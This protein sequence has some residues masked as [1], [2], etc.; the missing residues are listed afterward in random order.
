MK[1]DNSILPGVAAPGAKTVRA[2]KGAR[3]N[4]K[5]AHA[6]HGDNVELGITTAQLLTYETQLKEVEGVDAAKV[7]EVRRAIAEGR[8]QVNEEAVVDGLLRATVEQLRRM[9]R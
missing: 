9:K 1:I 4:E 5:S 6:P 8:F 3:R 7:E 2:G